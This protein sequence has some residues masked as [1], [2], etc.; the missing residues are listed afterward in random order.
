MSPTP[1]PPAENEVPSELIDCAA[2]FPAHGQLRDNKFSDLV[3]QRWLSK[4][5]FTVATVGFLSKVFLKGEYHVLALTA[6]VTL[7]N[8]EI[9]TFLGL[10]STV[11]Y[12][13]EALVNAIENRPDK[14]PLITVAN[15]HSCV[16]EP[17]LWGLLD[18]KH[19]FNQ[20]VWTH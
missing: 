9:F 20:V 19:I 4:S 8:V 15:H 10:N 5:A 1:D 11:T 16:D 7:D 2:L 3:S 18:L 6:S 13:R 17:L 14:V 12:N